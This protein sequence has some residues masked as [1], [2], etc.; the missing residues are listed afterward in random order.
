MAKHDKRGHRSNE[1]DTYDIP[2]K[3]PKGTPRTD[4][5]REQLKEDYK[6]TPRKEG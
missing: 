3:V 4:Q 2:V 5:A 6:N 1:K